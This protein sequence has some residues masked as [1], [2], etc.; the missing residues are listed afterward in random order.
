MIEADWLEYNEIYCPVSGLLKEAV[1]NLCLLD[2]IACEAY[3]KKTIE[4]I[5]EDRRVDMA[6]NAEFVAVRLGVE[7]ALRTESLVFLRKADFVRSQSSCGLSVSRDAAFVS[8]STFKKH[9]GVEPGDPGVS[10]EL[11]DLPFLM[12]P[13]CRG[14]VMELP[15]PEGLPYEK[16]STYA[17]S[18][19]MLDTQLLG[20]SQIFRS[21]Q[22]LDRYSVSTEQMQKSRPRVLRGIAGSATSYVTVRAEANAIE[23]QRQQLNEAQA[24]TGQ[25]GSA[26]QIQSAST[27][28]GSDDPF[29]AAPAAKKASGKAK[30]KAA[31]AAPGTPG[32]AA[33]GT[34]GRGRGMGGRSG[35]VMNRQDAA[36][37]AAMSLLA[38]VSSSPIAQASPPAAVGSGLRL[39]PSAQ[40]SGIMTV[41]QI[42]MGAAPG[43]TR[44]KAPFDEKLNFC[45]FRGNLISAPFDGNGI[46]VSI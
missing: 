33:P 40:T 11:V 38:S 42:M 44:R 5:M 16:I 34:P 23:V 30:A 21:G 4:S 12:R 9:F 25:A 17:T 20:P 31:A 27:L 19:R 15:L 24:G 46:S 28:K 13:D 18:Q 8:F 22:A 39:D 32:R 1:G 37:H 14:A 36:G 10:A 45:V 6:F 7:K 35:R 26:M 41:A 43:H 3:P 29:A 2:G